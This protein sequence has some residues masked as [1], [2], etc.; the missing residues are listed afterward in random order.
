MSGENRVKSQ[1]AAGSRVTYMC[2]RVAG[3][4]RLESPVHERLER[5]LPHNT[6]HLVGRT[7]LHSAIGGE[8]ELH[9]T[10]AVVSPGVVPLGRRASTSEQ[11]VTLC[12]TATGTT[13]RPRRYAGLRKCKGRLQIEYPGNVVVEAQRPE[14]DIATFRAPRLCTVRPATMRPRLHH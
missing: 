9:W 1:Q 5:E 6:V 3:Q 13:Q 12:L 14:R 4:W 7:V 10:H 11:K 2:A 8:G